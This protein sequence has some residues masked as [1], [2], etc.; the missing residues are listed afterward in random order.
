METSF[1]S[2]AYPEYFYPYFRTSLSVDAGCGGGDGGNGKSAAAASCGDTATNTT[3][4]G[5][6]DAASAAD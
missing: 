2:T 4:S 6:L 3:L 1:A 5:V